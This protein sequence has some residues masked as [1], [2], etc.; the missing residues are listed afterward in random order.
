M[1][2]VAP[3]EASAGPG[4][5]DGDAPPT[6]A[7]A[8]AAL[9]DT[10]Q[11]AVAPRRAGRFEYKW[12]ALAVVLFAALPSPAFPG[13]RDLAPTLRV[14]VSRGEIELEK[15]RL[16]R[17][18]VVRIVTP[19]TLIED[20]L[21]DGKQNNYLAA[22]A[23]AGDTFALAY[24]D[25]STGYSAATALSGENAFDERDW[26]RQGNIFGQRLFGPNLQQNLDVVDNLLK[27]ADDMARELQE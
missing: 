23:S 20:Q 27:V 7:A 4:R 2:E 17:R 5:Q 15:R 21:L 6:P 12:V 24:A 14:Q 3:Q 16:Q 18:D 10:A 22:I 8:A 13:L 11:V 26:R 1:A 25:V 19:G 9:P